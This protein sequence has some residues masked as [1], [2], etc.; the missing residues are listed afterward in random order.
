MSLVLVSVNLVTQQAWGGIGACVYWDWDVYMTWVNCHE[1]QRVLSGEGGLLQVAWCPHQPQGLTWV[2]Q[3]DSVA[4]KASQRL[5]YFGCLRTFQVS[6]QMQS[7]FYSCI[8]E[9]VLTGNIWTLILNFLNLAPG[10]YPS[11]L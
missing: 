1:Y 11:I 9:S 5:F 4:T 2:L 8:I 3:T 10:K 7:N 6:S